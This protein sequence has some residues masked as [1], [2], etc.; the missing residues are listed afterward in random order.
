MEKKKI[1][2][3]VGSFRKAS[4]NM[5]LAKIAAEIMDS[6]AV[7]TFLDYE[8]LPFMNQDIEYPTPTVVERVKNAVDNSDGV[9][10]FTP[11]YNANIPGVLKNLLDWLSRPVKSGDRGNTV[12]AQKPV[13]ISGAAGKSKASGALG[14]LIPL[15][16]FM[17]MKVMDESATGIALSA[18][19]FEN[20]NL[21]L[22]EE[23]YDALKKQA[24]K[25]MAFIV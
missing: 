19:S 5:Q 23:Q 3:I 13:T 1:V 25:F 9:W 10:I 18:E 6:Q 17:G 14:Q 24:E 4:F 7:V 20:N 22:D 2:I 15:L 16:N 12:V 11:E 8:N 21:I